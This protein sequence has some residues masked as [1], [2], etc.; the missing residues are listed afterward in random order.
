MNN[1]AAW[2]RATAIAKSYVNEHTWGACGAPPLKTTF[3]WGVWRGEA[4]PHPPYFA[5]KAQTNGC[6]YG[7]AV[8]CRRQSD[9]AIALGSVPPPMQTPRRCATIQRSAYIHYSTIQLFDI[10]TLATLVGR[11]REKMGMDLNKIQQFAE[12]IGDISEKVEQFSVDAKDFLSAKERG[13]EPSAGT[14]IAQMTVA[15]DEAAEVVNRSFQKRDETG[16]YINI[17]SPVVVP[18]SSRSY[19]WFLPAAVLLVVGVVGLF[20]GALVGMIPGLGNVGMMF[21]GPHYWLLLLVFVGFKVWKNSFVMVPDGCQALITKF[22]KLETIAPAGRVWLINPWKKVSYIVNTTKEYPYNAPIRE[23]PTAGRVNASVDLFLQ[24]RVENPAEFIFTLGGAQGF[25]EKLLNAISEVTRAL[26]YEQKA[27]SIYDLVGESTQSLL[28]T[29]N[30]Q[31]LPAVRF[32]NANIT[33]AEPSNR[34]YRMDLAAPEMVRVAKEA[35]T[36][37]Y[38]LKLRKEQDEGDFNKELAALRENLSQIRAE[39]ARFQA[40]M[41]TAHEKEVNRANAYARQLMVEAESEAKANAALLEAQALDIRAINSAYFPEI[42]EYRFHQDVLDRLENIADRLPQMVNI[43]AEADE[44]INFMHVA[45]QLLGIEDKA[46][47]SDE[48]IQ[49]IRK[50]MNDITARIKE[51]TNQITK[52]MED[53]PGSDGAEQKEMVAEILSASPDTPDPIGQ[54]KGGDA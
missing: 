3:S 39:I 11:G 24:F 18:K 30:K 29:L 43:G 51:R 53:Q 1:Y 54:Q 45:R 15:T 4:A 31:F 9:F 47:Y 37:E 12:S 2:L 50:R 41:D 14:E 38:E 32:V 52:L 33:H 22:G 21:F 42:L 26:I 7:K 27:E 5:L 44:Y 6:K 49:A 36:Y 46:L 13:G 8:V 40:Q 17:I 28:D 20:S 16:Q 10:T 25:T 34:Q 19:L 48:D 35:Y 23:A